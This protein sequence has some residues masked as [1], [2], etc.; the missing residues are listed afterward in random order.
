MATV[1]KSY[2]ARARIAPPTEQLKICMLAACPFPA[3]HGTPGSIREM[4]EAVAGRGHEVHV[5]TY[6]FG[7]DI[8]LRGIHL[9][10]IPPWTRETRVVVGP[11]RRRPLYDLQ[12]VFRATSVIRE[13]R[14]DLIHAHG[15]E[16]ALVAWL[17]RLRTG[18]PVVYSAHNTM[19]DEL[20]SYC[21][22]RPRW[23][24]GFLARAL[25]RHVPR[26]ADRCIPHSSNVE[27]FLCRQG[28]GERTE[29]V[30]N[31]GIDPDLVAAGDGARVRDRY[32]LG[33]GPVILY[34]GVLDRFQRLDLLLEAFGQLLAT[35]TP[36]YLLVVVTI[37]QPEHA[38]TLLR[39]AAERGVADRVIVTEPQPLSALGDFLHAGDVAVVPRP[40]A[41]GYPIKLLNY[42]AAARPCVLFESSASTGLEHRGN[43]FLA[44]PDT[45]AALAEGIHTVL[46]DAALRRRLAENG[47]AFVREHHD[48]RQIAEHVCSAYRHTL[49]A[50][51]HYS[52]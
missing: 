5:V 39:Q 16:A 18:L 52:R 29:P 49:E 42:M 6:H 41:P 11:T 7:E 38:A 12:M 4:A 15:Y 32:G 28:L 30:A 44:R 20:P 35:G 14:P 33:G 21:F 3:A 25:D 40:A 45:A 31:F 8:P 37:P 22:I 13:H 43:V 36:A 47:S 26:L 19:A 51:G 1:T 2:W 27:R 17:C 48:R 34:T 46:G 50:A 24:A 23:A 9:H 10:R